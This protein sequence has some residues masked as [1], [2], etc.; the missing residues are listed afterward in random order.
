MDGGSL[1]GAAIRKLQAIGRDAEWRQCRARCRRPRRCRQVR[2]EAAMTN[3]SEYQRSLRF[4]LLARDDLPMLQDWIHRPHVGQ[5]WD[6]PSSA[7]DIEHH[8]LPT[9]DGRS[10]TRAFIAELASEPIGFIQV[11]RVMDSGNG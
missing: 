10:T 7:K 5:W 9:I 6:E 11:Y 8:Y 4:R 3:P 2:V 1:E